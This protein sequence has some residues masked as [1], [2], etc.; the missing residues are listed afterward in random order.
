MKKAGL[1]FLALAALAGCVEPA[2]VAVKRS[3]DFA[4]I[5]RVAVLD[6]AGTSGNV[7]AD[8][9][10]QSLLAAGADVVERR[11]I[12]ALINEGKLGAQGILDPATAKEMG[13]LLGVD[14]LFTGSVT[15]FSP[16]R[17]YLVF[18]NSHQTTELGSSSAVDRGQ[19]GGSPGTDVITSDANVGLSARMVETETGSILWSAH[20]TYEGIDA[21]SAMGQICSSFVRSLEPIWLKKI[22]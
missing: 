3:F 18:T 13:K 15:T 8:N 17:S 2:D 9:M 10:V 19:V 14:A 20:L 7:A 12:G 16:E 11:Q 5:K 6:F 22:N 21:D 1:I 4:K